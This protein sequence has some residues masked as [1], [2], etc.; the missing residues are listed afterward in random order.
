MMLRLIFANLPLFYFL[1]IERTLAFLPTPLLRPSL[2]EVTPRDLVFVSTIITHPKNLILFH[3]FGPNN[4]DDDNQLDQFDKDLL[5]AFGNDDRDE[6][7]I[8]AAYSAFAR[9]LQNIDEIDDWGKWKDDISEDEYLISAEEA[10]DLY[11]ETMGD[12]T[13]ASS[14]D[15][16]LGEFTVNVPENEKQLVED[17]VASAMRAIETIWVEQKGGANPVQDYFENVKKAGQDKDD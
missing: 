16:D 15:I 12:M 4:S 17:V 11:T 6:A 3:N 10:F 2:N 9:D 8:N 7:V 5:A 14:G 13:L 1:R